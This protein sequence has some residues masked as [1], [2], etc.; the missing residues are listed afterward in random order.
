M[1]ITRTLSASVAAFILGAGGLRAQEKHPTIPV[2]LTVVFSE[3][4]GEKKISSL[5][6]VIQLS[7]SE[8]SSGSLRMGIRVPVRQGHETGGQQRQIAEVT[9]YEEVGTSIDCS[10]TPQE[11]GRFSVSVSAERNSLYEPSE[12][13]KP[14]GLARQ[15]L[16]RSRV[17]AWRPGS[18]PP[19]EQPVFGGFRSREQWLMR[20][21]ETLEA[22]TATDPITGRVT[23]MDVTLNAEK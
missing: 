14:G 22:I 1:K 23:K 17:E 16:E 9:E 3:Y 12:P 15:E 2:K 11:D 8:R 5:P 13:G 20:D 19:T 6:Y 21:G 7:A 4:D 10:V 18:G